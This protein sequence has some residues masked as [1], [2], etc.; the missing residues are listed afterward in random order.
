MSRG[1]LTFSASAGF[2]YNEI[3]GLRSRR[4]WALTASGLDAHLL[5]E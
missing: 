4:E 2:R 5:Q 1:G 3:L